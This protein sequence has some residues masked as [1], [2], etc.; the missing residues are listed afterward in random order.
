MSGKTR[1]S[2]PQLGPY[3]WI[4]FTDAAH[5]SYKH[6]ESWIRGLP[7]AAQD[8]LR[9]QLAARENLARLGRLPKGATKYVEPVREFPGLVELKWDFYEP[10]TEKKREIRQYHGEPTSPK[11]VLVRLH[12]H[13]K[14]THGFLRRVIK[15]LQVAEF[16]AADRRFD[17]WCEI[18]EGAR[19]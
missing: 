19:R 1:C 13:V 14:R 6:F 17:A 12:R 16:D 15:Q 9:G 2:I 4:D 5:K 8:D 10:H 3:R 18:T 7:P 11:D